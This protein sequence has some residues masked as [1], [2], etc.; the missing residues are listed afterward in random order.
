MKILLLNPPHQSIGS[1]MAG[2]HLPPLGLLSIGGPLID[3]G[4]KVNLLDADFYNM[5]F[6][7]IVM[8]FL[9]YDADFVLIGHSGSTS[10][11]PIINSLSKLLKQKNRE[12]RIIVGGVFPTFHWKE[13]LE[14]NPSIDVIVCGEGE[15]IVLD[16]FTA[17]KNGDDLK[18]VDGIAYNNFGIFQKNKPA[19]LIENLDDYRIG[20]ELM[21]D[22]H[23]TYLGG[24]KAVIIQFSRGCTYPCT[25]CGQS[26]FWKKWRNRNPEK[27]ADEIEMLHYKYRIKVVNFADE[28]PS[29]N[30]SEWIKFLEALNAKKLN[31]RLIGSIRADNI[32]RDSKFIPLYKEV[33]FE[34]FLLGV[35]SYNNDVL[36]KIRKG[37]TISKDKHAIKLLRA[38]GIISMATYVVGFGEET[39]GSFMSSFIQLLKYDP[40]QIQILYATPHKWTPYFS[41]IQ[42][43]KVIL[44]DQRKWDYKHQVLETSNLKPWQVILLVKMI[45]LLMQARPKSIFRKFFKHDKIYRKSMG[46]YNKIGARVWFYELF[47]Y[48]FETKMKTRTE[49]LEEFWK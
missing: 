13:V 20:W 44:T 21:G 30:I 38:N 9:N 14:N 25:Y 7:K 15:Q 22:Y 45:E 41:E 31:L 32:V 8:E 3:A 16:L 12:I 47:S 10:A 40:D 42:S 26:L 24:E 4:Y 19:K 33:G 34:R 23:Y 28:N 27:L 46:W 37:G 2:E 5:S 11:Q 6:S 49:V 17:F 39:L 43:K 48:F 18:K 1:R 29:S 35:E 36:S